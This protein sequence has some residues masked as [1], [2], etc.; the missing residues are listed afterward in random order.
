MWW[1]SESVAI[2][3]LVKDSS[4]DEFARETCSK[5]LQTVAERSQLAKSSVQT[6][7]ALNAHAAATQVIQSV[8]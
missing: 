4:F 2:D 1:L 7:T 3:R 6:D 8:G 5:A